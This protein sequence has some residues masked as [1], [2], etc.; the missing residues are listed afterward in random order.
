[1]VAALAMAACSG[2]G[3]S[4]SGAG[5]GAAATSGST[6]A[7][8][9]ETT[10]TTGATT[11]AGGAGGAGCGDMQTDVDNC[12]ACD[13]RCAPGQTCEAGV[14]TCG[15]ASVSFAADVVPILTTSCAKSLC[16]AGAQPKAGLDLTAANAYGEL[17]GVAAGQC[18]GG[19]RM[20]VEPG[21]P[22]ESYVIDKVMNTD[23]CGNNKKMPPSTTLSTAKIQTIADWICMGA[24]DN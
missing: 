11:G 9:G 4:T 7:T 17:V 5:G 24:P 2:A 21:Q 3:D 22:S 16:H 18:S 19:S 15:Q 14:C 6:T 1:M 13:N 20:R 23:M 12:G 10:G 8:T